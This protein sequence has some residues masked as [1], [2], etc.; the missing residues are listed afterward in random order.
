MALDASNVYWIANS[1]VYSAP[2]H[3]GIGAPLAT[4]SGAEFLA[5]IGAT[6]FVT[7]PAGVVKIAT[8]GVAQTPVSVATGLSGPAGPIVTDASNAYFVS[9]FGLYKVGLSATAATATKV[10]MLASSATGLVYDGS[11]TVYVGDAA[12]N[13]YAFPT[14][15]GPTRQGSAAGAI[16]ALA[17]D[18]F[19][20]SIYYTTADGRLLSLP[21][22]LAGGSTQIAT[23]LPAPGPGLVSDGTLLYATTPSGVSSIRKSDGMILGIATGQSGTTYLAEDSSAVYFMTSNGPIR[24]TK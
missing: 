18:P 7:V 6:L 15:A 2:I 13:I 22:S 3:G 21:T 4:V 8:S 11:S 24:A 10:I 20:A 17:V 14:T 16:T 5:V 12:Q 19:G 1:T 9:G 23:G